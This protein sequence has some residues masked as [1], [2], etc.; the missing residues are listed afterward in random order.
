MALDF[1]A[2][3]H[4]L[5]GF[6]ADGTTDTETGDDFDES[7]AQ[8]MTDAAREVINILPPKLKMKCATTT[9]LNNSTTT[10]DMDSSGDILFV[11]RLSADSDGFQIACREIPPIYSGLTTDSSSLYYATATD[12]VYWV[13]PNTSGSDGKSA[14]LYVKPTPESIQVAYVHHVNYPT[15]TAGD[16]ETYDICQKTIIANFPDEAENLV[17]LRASITA[18]EYLLAI[19]EDAELYIP[20]ISTLKAQYQEGVMALQTGSIIP[21]QKQGAR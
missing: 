6:D 15:F 8:W 16:T 3:I 19:E 9:T 11:T 18:A 2:R 17:V 12:P 14:T 20:V 13:D 5:T 1:A 10:M 4:A 7:A 21:P